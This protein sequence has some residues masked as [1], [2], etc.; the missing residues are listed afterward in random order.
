MR[1]QLLQGSLTV[2]HT[3]S[4]EKASCFLLFSGCDI[5]AFTFIVFHQRNYVLNTKQREVVFQMKTIFHIRHVCS[6]SAFDEGLRLGQVTDCDQGFAFHAAFA[7]AKHRRVASVAIVHLRW[8]WEVIF[9][10]KASP[11]MTSCLCDDVQER[12]ADQ[13]ERFKKQNPKQEGIVVDGDEWTKDR[14]IFVPRCKRVRRV[15][16]TSSQGRHFET[17][18]NLVCVSRWFPCHVTNDD[19]RHVRGNPRDAGLFRL[20]SNRTPNKFLAP[21]LC[22]EL[23]FLIDIFVFNVNLVKVELRRILPH[24]GVLTPFSLDLV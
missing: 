6:S 2:N 19:F 23:P 13:L 10:C 15:D 5:Q 20:L 3:K 22:K 1:N 14:A 9:G 16:T 7:T 17:E 11:N 21:L 24:Q 12:S 18:A 8:V 4:W